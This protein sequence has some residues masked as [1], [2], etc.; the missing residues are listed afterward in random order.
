MTGILHRQK[1]K[2]VRNNFFQYKSRAVTA[3]KLEVGI[4]GTKK[5]KFEMTNDDWTTNP[6]ANS[7]FA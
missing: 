5:I 7:G 1:K 4:H 2:V 3:E 6:I